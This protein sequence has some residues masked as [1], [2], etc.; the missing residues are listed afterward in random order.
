MKES[1]VFIGSVVLIARHQ[2]IVIGAAGLARHIGNL[3]KVIDFTVDATG[4]SSRRNFESAGWLKAR[5]FCF[6]ELC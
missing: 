6:F 2:M 5:H 3:P 1:Q 4:L